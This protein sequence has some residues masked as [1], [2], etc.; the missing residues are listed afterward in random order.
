MNLHNK[1]SQNRHQV[2]WTR[3]FAFASNHELS[4]RFE[5]YPSFV[6]GKLVSYL[7]LAVSST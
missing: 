4:R 5:C 2:G 1:Y 7:Q 3:K 6:G